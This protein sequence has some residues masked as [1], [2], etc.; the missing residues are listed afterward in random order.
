VIIFSS[1]KPFLPSTSPVQLSAI[2]SWRIACP[3]VPIFLFGDAHHLRLICEKEAL[4]YGGP[5]GVTQQGGEILADMFIQMTTEYP[6]E[7]LL[8]LNSDILLEPHFMKTMGETDRISAPWLAS[9]RRW[10][11]PPWQGEA[12]E[13]EGLQAFFEGIDQRGHYGP[14][15]AMD[16]FLLRGINLRAMPPFRIGHAGWDNWM[17]YH[18]RMRGI[19]V[20]DLSPAIRACHCD[21]DYSYAKGNSS[22]DCRDGIL[23]EENMGILQEENRRFHLG[24]STHEWRQ[25]KPVARTGRSFRHRQFEAWLA[26]NPRHQFWIRPLKRLFHPLVKKLE[27]ATDLAEDWRLK[28]FPHA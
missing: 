6:E 4:R 20:L 3:R 17:M 8:Y 15:F 21:H 7:T 14:V 2:R 10:C 5:L 11:L 13:G 28:S 25:G 22:P 16:L 18:A 9:C 24:H 27:K 1:P 12:R 26:K 23:E 19:P